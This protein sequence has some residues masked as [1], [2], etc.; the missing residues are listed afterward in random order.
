MIFGGLAVSY[1]MIDFTMFERMDCHAEGH[2]HKTFACYHKYLLSDIQIENDQWE[3]ELS[4]IHE[5][6]EA[7]DPRYAEIVVNKSVSVSYRSLYSTDPMDKLHK[8]LDAALGAY[9]IVELDQNKIT[10]TSKNK[11]QLPNIVTPSI[12]VKT[13]SGIRFELS[14]LTH[15]RDTDVFVPFNKRNIVHIP[16]TT[17]GGHYQIPLVGDRIYLIDRVSNN[18]DRTFTR[19]ILE[20]THDAH[21]TC[22]V[23]KLD[24]PIDRIPQDH[25]RND[26]LAI[27]KPRF[28][29]NNYT[30]NFEKV[31]MWRRRS[32]FHEFLAN[33]ASHTG[34]CVQQIGD[35]ANMSK[36]APHIVNDYIRNNRLQYFGAAVHWQSYQE[37]LQPIYDQF[38][39]HLCDHLFILKSSR[40]RPE[41]LVHID[42]H[43]ENPEI[44]VTGSLTWPVANCDSNTTTVWYDAYFNN[45]R[46]FKYGREDVTITDERISLIEKDRYVF[47]TA[48]WN[49]VILNHENWHTV[50]NNT[51]T[52][53]ERMLL[54]WR[55]KPGISWNELM[56]MTQDIHV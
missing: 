35:Y 51:E 20:V 1:N 43:H 53:D 32:D 6:E 9:Y 7:N 8:G 22:D 37:L 21:C 14:T 40:D 29:I 10:M 16:R 17:Q 36:I 27:R 23:L 34:T 18:R 25:D 12:Y 33:R 44:P 26:G 45:E 31:E 24:L 30:A 52:S 28:H 19:E 3:F 39:S 49:S 42:Y 5:H 54:Q 47:D 41:Y 4:L 48:K 2:W 56:E 15:G 13:T 50:Y 38:G 46:I 11:G 55:F